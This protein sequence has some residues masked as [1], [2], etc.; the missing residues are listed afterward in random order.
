[1]TEAKRLAAKDDE[2]GP[3]GVTF[4]I[5]G[6]INLAQLDAEIKAAM[7]WRVPAGLVADYGHIDERGF[8]G[9]I[10][11]DVEVGEEAED[12]VARVTVTHDKP[13]A[14]TIAQVIRDHEPIVGWSAEGSLSRAALA[15]IAEERPL[16]NPE[17]Q[18][19][20]RLLLSDEK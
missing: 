20:I 2:H 10:P 19:A 13:D 4:E 15:K 5:E 17:M 6:P 12:E 8:F 7:N 11:A 9:P 16:T 14:K 3:G 18:R 1:M